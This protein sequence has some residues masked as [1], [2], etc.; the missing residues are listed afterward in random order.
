MKIKLATATVAIIAAVILGLL[1]GSAQAI[2][3]PIPGVDIIVKK[4]PGGVAI[5]AMTDKDGKFVFTNLAA[6]TYQLSVKMPQ[7]RALINIS[8]SNIRHPGRSMEN[9]VE[10]VNVSIE[11]GK[12]QPAPVE[13][14]ITKNGGTIKGMVTRAE[15]PKSDNRSRAPGDPISGTQVGLEHDPGSEI[16]MANPPKDG[17]SVLYKGHKGTVRIV[18]KAATINWEGGFVTRIVGAPQNGGGKSRISDQAQGGSLSSYG[19]ATPKKG[20]DGILR[21]ELVQLPKSKSPK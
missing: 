6:G 14:E 11:L 15:T 16:V 19:T 8:H 13:I 18:K 3:N 7:T 10:V 21:Y 5:H 2:D 20:S 4:H 1:G 17:S 9:G 12:E